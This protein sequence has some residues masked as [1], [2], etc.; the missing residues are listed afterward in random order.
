MEFKSQEEDFCIIDQTRPPTPQVEVFDSESASEYPPRNVYPSSMTLPVGH[1][2]QQ[3]HQ[4]NYR[5]HL[6]LL[7][8]R[9]SPHAIFGDKPVVR[10]SS[11]VDQ[12]AKESKVKSVATTAS[13]TPIKSGSNSRGVILQGLSGLT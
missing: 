2:V 5:Q 3:S 10:F 11:L 7:K 9:S 12:A 8:Q 13:N 1:H 6:A 4:E